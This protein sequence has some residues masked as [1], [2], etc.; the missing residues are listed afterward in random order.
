VSPLTDGREPFALECY[1]KASRVLV[2]S[3]CSASQ[4]EWNEAMLE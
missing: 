4:K 1:D 2:A 3:L